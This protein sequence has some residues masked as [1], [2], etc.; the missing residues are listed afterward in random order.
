[1]IIFVNLLGGLTIGVTQLGLGVADA[2][3]IYSLLTIGDGMVAQIP[4]LFA[5]LS[6]GLIVSRVSK[7]GSTENLGTSIHRQ[8][9]AMPKVLLIAGV[10]SF[11]FALVPGFP[12]GTFIVLGL[13]LMFSGAM[14]IPD[15]RA[16]IEN[17]AAP[18]FDAVLQ[19]KRSSVRTPR[20]PGLREANAEAFDVTHTIALKLEFPALNKS[21]HHA[22]AIQDHVEH[23]LQN[24]QNRIGI[25]LPQPHYAWN[26]DTPDRWRLFVFEVPVASGLISSDPDGLENLSG[27]IDQ[28][29]TKHGH[30]FVGL[31]EVSALMT[32][33]NADYPDIV[34]EALRLVQIANL[35]V[36]LRKLVEEDQS[37]GICVLFSR[38]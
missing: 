24:Y 37:S 8:L 30:L 4:A 6:A 33:T 5:A 17:A 28:A 35:T 27:E 2:A 10:A 1:M 13:F 11:C 16:R 32:R 19:G 14:L 3:S 7:E 23:S 25:A 36:I 15:W 9:T 22:L 20:R 29:L 26:A 18:T 38:H 21:D 31:Q 12:S 34:R